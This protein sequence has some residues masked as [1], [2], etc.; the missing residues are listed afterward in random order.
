MLNIARCML[1]GSSDLLSFISHL[2]PEFPPMSDAAKVE[3]A[4]DDVNDEDD[5]DDDEEDFAEGR[6]R[7]AT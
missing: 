1:I 6:R 5:D 4:K 3:H 2:I 7:L